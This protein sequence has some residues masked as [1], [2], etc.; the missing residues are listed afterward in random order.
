MSTTLTNPPAL[1]SAAEL[2]TAGKA[3][4]LKG[5]K[6]RDHVTAGLKAQQST[7]DAALADMVRNG[8]LGKSLVVSKSGLVTAK[9]QPPAE[10]SA[11]K[12]AT[13]EKA[14]AD[15]RA[16]IAQLKA[17]MAAHLPAANAAANQTVNVPASAVA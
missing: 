10:V 17:L 14:L 2:R 1:K 6:L 16:E 15:A 5:N 13:T 4:G 8:Y 7:F 11:T 3:A 9:F 12:A